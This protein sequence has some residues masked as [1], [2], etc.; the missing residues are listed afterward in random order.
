MLGAIDSGC[1]YLSNT[2]KYKK[3]WLID[4]IYL[5]DKSEF[6]GDADA[7]ENSIDYRNYG[8]PLSKRF[9]ALKMYFVT[10]MYGL[11]GLQDYQ[12]RVLHLAK[13]FESFVRAD[14][15]FVVTSPPSLGVFC[16]RQKG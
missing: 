12:R 4:A 9:R 7:K 3:P 10:R 2:H 8:V 16:F 1:L 11:N 14:K 5:I 13:Y 15:R 6:G